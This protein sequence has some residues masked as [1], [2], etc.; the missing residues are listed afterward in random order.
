MSSDYSLKELF[1]IQEEISRLNKILAEKKVRK[2]Y[3]LA[4]LLSRDIRFQG[5][6]ALKRA[7]HVIREPVIDQF[8]KYLKGRF[9]CVVKIKLGEAEKLLSPE[10]VTALCELK[11][12]IHYAVIKLR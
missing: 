3:I 8:R 12:E 7:V 9:D 5:D 1:E 4:G 10:I 6:Y 2:E 11:P